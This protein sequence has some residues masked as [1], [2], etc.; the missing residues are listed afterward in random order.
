LVVKM[1]R[2]T[3]TPFLTRMGQALTYTPA[4]G[5]GVSILGIPDD[6]GIQEVGDREGRD[7]TE[8]VTVRIAQT[9]ALGVVAPARGD[10]A[11]FRA[12]DWSVR[13]L[14]DEDG[15]W[16][17][18]LVRSVPAVRTSEGRYTKKVP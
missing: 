13:D 8:R 4:G 9:A 10:A 14:R 1:A 12:R 2:D 16:A 17:L 18:D 6:I 11:T 7:L 15:F 3:V 5:A